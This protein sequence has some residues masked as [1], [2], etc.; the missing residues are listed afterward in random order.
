M[1]TTIHKPENFST[2]KEIY[3][4][5]SVDKNGKQGIVG[6]TEGDSPEFVLVSLQEGII[7]KF[8]HIIQVL[9]KDYPEGEIRIVKFS[10]PEVLYSINSKSNE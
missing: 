8:K 1:T 2:G 5:M 7:H 10:N 9:R 4:V 3:A 6:F